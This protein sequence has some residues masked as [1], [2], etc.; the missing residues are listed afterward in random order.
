MAVLGCDDQ[1]G[2]ATDGLCCEV[3]PFVEQELYDLTVPGSGRAHQHGWAVLD[4]RIHIGATLQQDPRCFHMAVVRRKHQ[5]RLPV[6]GFGI[7]I[8]TFGQQHFHLV[9]G[10]GSRGLDQL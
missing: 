5:R 9:G 6:L 8:S 1:G 4:F 10:A 3:S 2:S 7:R